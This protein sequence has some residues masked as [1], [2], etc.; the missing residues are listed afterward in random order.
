MATETIKLILDIGTPLV[1]R[2]LLYDAL[3]MTFREVR[4]RRDRACPV[5]GENPTVTDLI[6]YEAFCGLHETAAG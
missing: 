3:E 6:D 2:L 4:L 5:C 1:G